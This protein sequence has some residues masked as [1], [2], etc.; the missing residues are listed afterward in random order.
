VR[1]RRFQELRSQWTCWPL[2]HLA[3]PEPAREAQ[4]QAAVQ[5]ESCAKSAALVAARRVALEPSQRREPRVP[6][7]ALPELPLGSAQPAQR[8]ELALP[9]RLPGSPMPAPDSER[10]RL[11][12]PAASPPEPLP[13]LARPPA[14][15]ACGGQPSSPEWEWTARDAPP[16]AARQAR[17]AAGVWAWLA[18][19][20]AAHP[21]PEPCRL[22]I[23]GSHPWPPDCSSPAWLWQPPWALRKS[24]PQSLMAWPAKSRRPFL[25]AR[26]PAHAPGR[27]GLQS[28]ARVF[29]TPR[30]R[31]RQ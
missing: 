25:L 18:H 14:V 30:R 1:L 31:P 8:L 17:P 11:G 6:G 22:S 12:P 16:D 27:G 13:P 7:L 5:L 20:L 3:G 2:A 15:R 23:P 26:L 19:G 28:I 29:A 4:L 21:P 24:C 10:A 9:A